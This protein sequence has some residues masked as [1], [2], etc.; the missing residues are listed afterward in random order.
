MKLRHNA[1]DDCGEGDGRASCGLRT[2]MS[3]SCLCPTWRRFCRPAR[4]DE[5]PAEEGDDASAD[6][7]RHRRSLLLRLFLLLLKLLLLLQIECA[8][9]AEALP[10]ITTISLYAVVEFGMPRLEHLECC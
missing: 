6:A 3:P 5:V 1:A 2:L 4:L 9:C 10:A 8:V 7:R